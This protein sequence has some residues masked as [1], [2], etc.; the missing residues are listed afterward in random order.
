M[1]NVGR[2]TLEQHFE[3][4]CENINTCQGVVLYGPMKGGKCS[5]KTKH[6]VYIAVSMHHMII[7][8]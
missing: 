8:L 5:N 2:S 7:I 6:L 1:S 3:D 4:K